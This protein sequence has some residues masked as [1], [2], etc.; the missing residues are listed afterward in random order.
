MGFSPDKI[1]SAVIISNPNLASLLGPSNLSGS[2]SETGPRGNSR[3]YSDDP[4]GSDTGR[5]ILSNVG[6]AV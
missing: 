1:A 2:R 3:L 4:A 5:P 6:L